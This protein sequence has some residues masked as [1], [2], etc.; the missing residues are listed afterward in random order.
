M[1][2]QITLCV[3]QERVGYGLFVMDRFIWAGNTGQTERKITHTG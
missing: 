1:L 2:S 3:V